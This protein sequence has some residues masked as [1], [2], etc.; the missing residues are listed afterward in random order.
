MADEFDVET[1]HATSRLLRPASSHSTA[2]D[3]PLADAALSL[4]YA[5]AGQLDEAQEVG[6]RFRDIIARRYIPP[7]YFGMLYAGIGDR[8]RAMVWLSKACAERADGLT[9][10]RRRAHDG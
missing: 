5:V 9:W 8:D 6:A 10:S 4:A 1:W 7:T 2:G 3:F